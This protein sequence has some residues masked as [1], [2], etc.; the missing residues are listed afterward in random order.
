MPPNSTGAVIRNAPRC[1]MG[2]DGCVF[3]F[4]KIGDDPVGILQEARRLR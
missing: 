3:G 1:F 4:G 2:A